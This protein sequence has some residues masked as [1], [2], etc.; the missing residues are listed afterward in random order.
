VIPEEP[1]DEEQGLLRRALPVV[2]V[3]LVGALLSWGLF[4]LVTD[5]SDSRRKTAA[6][7]VKLTIVKPPPKEGANF[8]KSIF[9]KWKIG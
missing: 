8:K 4:S 6:P 1:I 9:Q 3:V 2:A 5:D 7:V